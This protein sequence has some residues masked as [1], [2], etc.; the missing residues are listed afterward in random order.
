[1]TTKDADAPTPA[2]GSPAGQ[3]DAAG[4]PTGQD[5]APGRED[6]KARFREA[7]DR[8]KAASHRSAQGSGNT[9]SVHGSE[10]TGPAQRT[11]RRR[12]GSA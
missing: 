3:D 1:M 6:A 5:D 9:G 10:T 7:L 8:K 12:S 11:F 2:A 4:S